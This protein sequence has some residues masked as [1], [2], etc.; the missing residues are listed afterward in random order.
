MDG[1]FPTGLSLE[2]E[3]EECSSTGE[4]RA[5]GDNDTILKSSCF[6]FSSHGKETRKERTVSRQRCKPPLC[7]L[8]SSS[9]IGLWADGLINTSKWHL[10]HHMK[11]D[12]Q[13]PFHRTCNI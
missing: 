3:R 8:R 9:T 5:M 4:D 12:Q 6:L 13:A 10:L 1:S 11:Y 7:P 2:R